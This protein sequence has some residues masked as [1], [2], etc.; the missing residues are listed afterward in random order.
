V[1]SVLFYVVE[2]TCNPLTVT[3]RP[4]GTA[5]DD[6]VSDGTGRN[7]TIVGCGGVVQLVRTPACH[8]GGREFESRRSRQFFK[9]SSHLCAP[10]RHDPE[11]LGVRSSTCQRKA[12]LAAH[13]H[14]TRSKHF[15]THS[16]L[17]FE[18]TRRTRANLFDPDVLALLTSK[19]ILP[20]RVSTA[21]PPTSSAYLLQGLKIFH[22][23]TPRKHSDEVVSQ[24]DRHLINSVPTHLF[25]C[26]PQFCVGID[27]A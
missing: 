4:K 16:A 14:G 10:G 13:R 2:S 19:S 5:R 15:Q 27:A 3:A 18:P 26:C 11:L 17:I 7:Q 20:K 9:E 25:H 8:A 12:S 21:P 24:H 1:P 23:V 22:Y 6:S